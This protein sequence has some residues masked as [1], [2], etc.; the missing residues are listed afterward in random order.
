MVIPFPAATAASPPIGTL[1]ERCIGFLEGFEDDPAQCVT[2]LLRQLRH[3][4][5]SDLIALPAPAARPFR[6]FHAQAMS[7]NRSA[8]AGGFSFMRHA[9]HCDGRWRWQVTRVDDSRHAWTTEGFAVVDD[10]GNLVEVPA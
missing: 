2:P 4:C 3:A 1:L 8:G 6:H 9:D 7:T 10:F 5:A